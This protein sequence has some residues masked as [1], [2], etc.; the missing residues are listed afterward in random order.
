MGTSQETLERPDNPLQE[1]PGGPQPRVNPDADPRAHVLYIIDVFKGIHAGGAERSLV[2]I[3]HHLPADRFRCSVAILG[4]DPAPETEEIFGCPVH[5]LPLRRTY[6]W[7]AAKTAWQLRSLIRSE[8]V[9]IVH[10]FFETSDLWGGGVARLSGCPLVVSSR[11]DMGIFRKPKHDLAYKVFGPHMD[12]VLTV[13]DQVRTHTIARDGMRPDKVVTLH[14]GISTARFDEPCDRAALRSALAL[15]AAS[16]VICTVG[17]IRHVKAFDIFIRAAARVTRIFP[18]AVFLI[19]GYNDDESCRT[20]LENLVTELNLS[21]NVF[22]VGGHSEVAPFLK[23]SD[24]FCLLSRSEGFSVALLE[25]MACSLPCVATRVGGNAEAVAENQTGFL[26]ESEDVEG[27]ADRILRLLR[28]PDRAR[29]M[30]AAGRQ[31]VEQ[32]FS[33]EKMVRKLTGLYD[34]LLQEKGISQC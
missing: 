24:I 17:N 20:E 22:F 30:G 5:L 6:N 10:T 7:S 21:R 33:V 29:Q 23:L 1:Q 19:V 32:D 8:N 11:R 13:S 16:P 27:A 14:N 12:L 4:R 2:S 9:S 25:A 26:V 15:D 31:A 3:T 18:Q 28:D 34:H